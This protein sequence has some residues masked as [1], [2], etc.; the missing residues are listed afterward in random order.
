MNIFRQLETRGINVTS[1]DIGHDRKLKCP[2]C[3]GRRKDKTDRSLSVKVTDY[4]H[5]YWKCHYP[6]CGWHGR[7]EPEDGRKMEKQKRDFTRPDYRGPIAEYPPEFIRFFH[8]RGIQIDIVKK[9]N[10]GFTVRGN[11][12]T[13]DFPYY[14]DGEVVN[15]KHRTL[16]KKFSQEANAERVFYGLQES[17]KK[18][19]CVIIVEGEIDLLTLNQ[20]G[21]NNVWAV[22]CGSEVKTKGAKFEEDAESDKAFAHVWNSREYLETKTKIILALDSDKVGRDTEEELARRLG[23]YRCERVRWPN[24]CKDA[25]E[26]LLKHGAGM[27]QQC[28]MNAT[29]YPMPDIHTFDDYREEI[30]RHFRGESDPTYSTGW[31]NLDDYMRIQTGQLSI[32]TGYPN[33][34]KSEFLDALALNMAEI[35]DW[36]IGLCSFENP[37][38]DH[39][40]KL[41]EKYIGKMYPNTYYGDE[42]KDKPVM[43]EK[44][45]DAAFP[46]LASHFPLIRN[47]EESPTIDW[48]L[49]K[50]K[51][52]VTRYGIKGL[53]IDPYNEMEHKRDKNTTETMYVSEMLAKIKSF[54]RVNQVHVW[55]IAHPTKSEHT[56]ISEPPSLRTI[57]G[58]ANWWNKA[59]IG[60]VVHRHN[61]ENEEPKTGIYI[62]KVRF[63]ACGKIGHAFLKYE[64]HSGRFSPFEDGPGYSIYNQGDAA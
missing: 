57:A 31:G 40:E 51:G 26:V 21:L 19:E 3:A 9:H 4:S 35:Y 20:A 30:Y 24:D 34:G 7:I 6:P 53:I 18:S 48:L 49:E 54:A 28:I 42:F 13:I 39:F 8:S 52:L 5:A 1:A 43:T 15:I 36:R 16:P 32:V 10:I 55:F 64:I 17:D 29:P 23:Q 45:L 12:L 25:N 27:I 22:P 50:A 11:G 41:A 60:V 63:K 44:E 62:R 38:T 59:D 37:V 2:E 14:K 56:K 33:N 47:E 58:S 46:W 61:E